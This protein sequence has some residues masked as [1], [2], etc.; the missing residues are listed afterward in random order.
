LA[1]PSRNFIIYLLVM[2]VLQIHKHLAVL[3]KGFEQAI[4][5]SFAMSAFNC[6]PL[7]LVFCNKP[8]A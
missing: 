5:R 4:F 3:A 8:V 1:N 7:F 6:Y 2:S